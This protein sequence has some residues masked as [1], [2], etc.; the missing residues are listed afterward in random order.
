MVTGEDVAS[1][2]RKLMYRSN[3]RGMRENDLILGS[4]AET[5]LASLNTKEMAKYEELLDELDPELFLWFT[6][7]VDPP[8]EWAKDDIFLRVQK[9]ALTFAQKNK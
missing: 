8:T 9:H 6:G 3:H 5:Y 1:L 2:K 7:K 4:F